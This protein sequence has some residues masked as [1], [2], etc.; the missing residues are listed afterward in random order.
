MHILHRVDAQD[1]AGAG[2][3][4]E[5]ALMSGKTVYASDKINDRTAGSRVSIIAC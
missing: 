3:T 1:M 5:I 2:R 4:P